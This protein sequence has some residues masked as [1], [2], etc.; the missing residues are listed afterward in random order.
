MG[1]NKKF[2]FKSDEYKLLKKVQ[3][4]P[5]PTKVR[6]GEQERVWGY[7]DKAEKNRSGKK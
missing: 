5:N 3:K 4:M 1:N 6:K 7:E 2:D